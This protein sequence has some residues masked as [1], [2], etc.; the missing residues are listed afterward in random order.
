MKKLFLVIHQMLPEVN[1]ECVLV[2][3]ILD[4]DKNLSKTRQCFVSLFIQ[5]PVLSTKKGNII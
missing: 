1:K 4:I 5:G 2:V 3:D